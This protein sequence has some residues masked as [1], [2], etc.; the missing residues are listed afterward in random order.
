MPSDD[1][2]SAVSLPVLASLPPAQYE[3]APLGRT[4]RPGPTFDEF[5]AIAYRH[6]KPPA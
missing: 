2:S 5:K 3:L 1:P 6:Q 4:A